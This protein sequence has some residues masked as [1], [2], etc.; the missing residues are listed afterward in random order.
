MMLREVGTRTCNVAALIGYQVKPNMY[1]R[2]SNLILCY[3]F[4]YKHNQI[5]C[6]IVFNLI[7]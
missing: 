2:I 5:P 6:E 7:Y 3:K 4:D 1:Y